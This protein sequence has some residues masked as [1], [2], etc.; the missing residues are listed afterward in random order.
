MITTEAA[1]HSMVGLKR[2]YWS[3]MALRLAYAAVMMWLAISVFLALMP[4][5]NVVAGSGIS[6]VTEVAR[7]MLDRVLAVAVLPGLFLVVLVIVAATIHGRDVRR[8]DPV[9]RFTR[10]QRRDGMARAAGLCEMEAGFRDR[11]SRPAEHGDH[12]YPWS[13]GGS[14]SLRNFVAACARCNRAKGARIPSPGQQERIERRRREHVAPDG[15]VSV[16]ERQPLP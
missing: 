14:T 2:I 13:K 7:G 4:K 5:A 11:C 6:S 1:E 8:R 12:F 10:Q 15:L 3:R 9:R 16:G